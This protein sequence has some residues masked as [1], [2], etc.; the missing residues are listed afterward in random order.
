MWSR[1]AVAAALAALLPGTGRA[2]AFEPT[3]TDGLVWAWEPG[4]ART[5]ALDNEVMLAAYL[6]I[7]A[8]QNKEARL[9]AFHTRTVITCVDTGEGSRKVAAL[10]C[11]IDDFAIS[12]AS[13]EGDR[14]LVQPILE[15]M[16]AKVTGA[17]L[18]VGLRYDGRL[19][20]VDLE[21]VEAGNRRES[22]M[23]E[24][25]RIVFAR[26]LSGFD[27]QLPPAGI[28]AE[29]VW[30]QYQNQL[31]GA[32]SDRGSQGAGEVAHLVREMDQG[33]AI[34]D[35]AG[36]GMVVP[37][38]DSGQARDYFASRL[39]AVAVF[40]TDARLLRERVWTVVG[41]PTASSAI[42]EGGAGVDYVQIG[43]ILY[44][45]E[46]ATPPDL[47]PTQEVVP[48]EGH[49]ESAVRGWAPAAS[50]PR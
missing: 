27:L 29:G 13:M 4:V 11:T 12:G 50:G 5:W 44:I 32:P 28:T 25:I 45:P 17:V 33:W 39:D 38:D 37:G 47:G 36:K 10:L 3:P 43:K 19:V 23:N 21:E 35:S 24:A 2:E 18:Q 22:R 42:A 46:G 49:V 14:G 31:F 40:D 8:D 9:V 34:I 15:E 20:G 1:I 6:W 26:A 30:G 48:P 7:M 16:D 41:K